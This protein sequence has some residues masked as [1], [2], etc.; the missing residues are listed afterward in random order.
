MT[1]AERY[2]SHGEVLMRAKCRGEL[3]GRLSAIRACVLAFERTES[4]LAI[5]PSKTPLT[6]YLCRV[7][8]INKLIRRLNYG[9]FPLI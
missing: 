6:V 1:L 2:L 5:F 4:R 7:P 3:S 8:K 9:L